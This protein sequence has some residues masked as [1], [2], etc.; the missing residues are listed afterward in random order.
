MAWTP[1]RK[2]LVR[3]LWARGDLSASQIAAQLGMA[4]RNMVIGLVYRMGLSL[5][6]QEQS[7]RKANQPKRL[8]PH[9]PRQ[10][11]QFGASRD[12]ARP[13]G[14]GRS[15]TLPSA[16]LAPPIPDPPQSERV[17]GRQIGGADALVFLAGEVWWAWPLFGVAKLPGMIGVLRRVY[18]WIAR[19]RECASG[20][21]ARHSSFVRPESESQ[22]TGR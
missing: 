10:P 11:K 15:L 16:V 6:L 13:K 12:P 14:L 18:R 3:E 17:D 4:T 22:H 9:R 5:S 19:H 8:H 1:E 2:E 21:C 7:R 20:S